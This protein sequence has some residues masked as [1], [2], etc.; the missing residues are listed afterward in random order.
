MVHAIDLDT[1]VSCYLFCRLF[2]KKIIF[3]IYDKYTAVRNITGF[4]G[5][6]IDHLERKIATKADLTLLADEERFDQM[7]IPLF[8]EN[9]L[10][11]ENVPLSSTK[12][13]IALPEYNGVWKIG[14]FGVL[15]PKHRGLEDIIEMISARD[16]VEFHIVGYGGLE[17]DIFKL[18]SLHTNIKYYGALTSEAGLK[19][20]SQ[21]HILVGLYYLSIPNHSYAAPNKYY[22][23]L[24]LGRGLL[25]TK[26]TSPGRKVE[27]FH[28]GWAIDEG[29]NS[30]V[31]WIKN[32]SK[33][34]V[35]KYAITASNLWEDHYQ[36]YYDENYIKKYAIH[37][38]EMLEDNL[39]RA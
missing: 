12:I 33:E 3:D 36:K 8:Q 26:N 25:T 14:Y 2:R 11:L 27:R 23:H 24:M 29:T 39:N 19:I 13:N 18:S 32:L 38:Q 15:E 6:A 20:M 30:L 10:V 4:L 28:T 22:E 21:M 17:Q 34:A 35:Y 37:V 5:R 7:K 9:C 31:H 1:A 16:D